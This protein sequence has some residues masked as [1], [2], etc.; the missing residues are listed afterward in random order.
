MSW[1][2]SAPTALHARLIRVDPAA[3]AR[4]EP[5]NGRRVV[6]ALEVIRLTGGPYD[7]ALPAWEYL[8]PDV[9]QIGLR[10]D[11][12]T[13]DARIARRV[14]QMWAAGFVAEVR[15][16]SERGLREGVTASRAL[17]YRQ[18]LQFLDGELE[19]A[20][21]LEQT[22]FGT[23]RFARRQDSWFRRDHRV[24]W[25]DHDDPRLVDQA[26]ALA[27]PR[28][29]GQIGGGGSPPRLTHWFH[30]Q[31]VVHEGTRHRERLRRASGPR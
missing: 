15:N 11:R 19:E 26:Y 27:G 5:N 1:L 7:A 13:L 29:D 18:I 30:A 21:A 31:M 10:L 12:P 9:V 24:H 16:L 8:L 20:Q 3:A 25:L 14:D 4:I 17:G 6:R 2:G 22:V 23:R 28:G